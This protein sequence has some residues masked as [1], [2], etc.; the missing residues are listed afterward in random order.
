MNTT[1]AKIEWHKRAK[2]VRS[3][4]SVRRQWWSR[5]G[6][7]AIERVDYSVPGVPSQWRALHVYR[8]GGPVGVI[9]L[10]SDR[11]KTRAGAVR[12]AEKHEAK[13]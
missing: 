6:L 9:E 12:S 3:D 2:L 10:I 4:V 11:H 8:N 13:K 7:Y 5:C 1:T